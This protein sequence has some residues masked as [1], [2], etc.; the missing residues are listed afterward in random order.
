MSFPIKAIMYGLNGIAGLVRMKVDSYGRQVG[1]EIEHQEIHEGNFY[2]MVGY[3][4]DVDVAAPKTWAITAP[5]NKEL[6]ARVVMESGPSGGIWAVYYGPTINATGTA[7]AIVNQNTNSIK[8][9]TASA[10][11]DCTTTADGTL[12]DID[13][14]GSTGNQSRT[15]GDGSWRDEIIIAPSQTFF[16][17]FTPAANDTK[18]VLKVLYYEV[19]PI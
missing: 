1:I 18:A 12:Y 6:H 2:R 5:A 10:V 16:F 17:R 15:G 11:E 14:Q 3:D 19:T 8:V 7:V 4:A 13:L 9:T